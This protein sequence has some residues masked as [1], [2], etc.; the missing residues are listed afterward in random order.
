MPVPVPV[1]S[2]V[3]P[4]GDVLISELPDGLAAAP[5]GSPIA[6]GRAWPVVAPGGL[7]AGTLVD[8]PAEDAPA[9]PAAPPAPPGPA[10]CAS[11]I[12][13]VSASAPANTIVAIFMGRFPLLVAAG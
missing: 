13:L 5:L 4:L 3:D 7:P 9:L 8:E 2:R 10:A 1:W 12:E 11:E 6:P